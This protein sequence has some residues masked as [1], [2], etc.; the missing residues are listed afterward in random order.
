MTHV[1]QN[2]FVHPR[3]SLKLFH[4]RMGSDKETERLK[5]PHSY[6]HLKYDTVGRFLGG[7]AQVMLVKLIFDSPLF[8]DV[9][10]PYSLMTA[11]VRS[12]WY[13]KGTEDNQIEILALPPRFLSM[14][15]MYVNSLGL[16]PRDKS[17]YKV[18]RDHLFHLIH[19]PTP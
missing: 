3:R 15:Y 13:C 19:V 4:T 17:I 6:A 18:S 12:R 16:R 9:C 8:Y 2:N 5:I 11:T 10:I 1:I 7:W 14:L